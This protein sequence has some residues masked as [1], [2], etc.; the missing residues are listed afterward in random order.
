M[1]HLAIT[2]PHILQYIFLLLPQ[3]DLLL[4][5]RVCR[6]WYEVI[7]SSKILQAALFLCPEPARSAYSDGSFE[8][9]PLLQSRF[10]SFF[11]PDLIIEP[12]KPS[13]HGVGPW[14]HSHWA[15]GMQ[16]WLE[17]RNRSGRPPSL[18]LDS[19]RVAAYKYPR[20]S[21]RRMIPCMPPPI[22]LQVNFEY[23]KIASARMVRPNFYT[24]RCLRFSNEIQ[25][26]KGA[27]TLQESVDNHLRQ[28]WLTFGLLHDIIEDAWFQSIPTPVS[29]VQFD[30]SFQETRPSIWRPHFIPGQG[31][32]WPTP[33]ETETI[34][35]YGRREKLRD[36][37]PE[38]KIGGPGRIL[39]HLNGH[40]VK[41]IRV[42]RYSGQFKVDKVAAQ[43]LI[44]DEEIDYK[45]DLRS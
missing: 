3:Q 1:A 14:L 21:W 34:H 23:R 22:E 2:T 8:L 19:R 24:L 31:V 7:S 6:R 37:F 17:G 13:E 30:Y 25:S 42:R 26:S 41:G 27:S 15:E 12:L 16:P 28:P 35:R 33:E 18:K 11:K 5:Q 4:V 38:K 45:S 36:I 29:E 43:Q 44:W 10:P 39:V 20:A 40:E 32:S 9:N